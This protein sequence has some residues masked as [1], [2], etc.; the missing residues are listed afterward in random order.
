MKIITDDFAL[1]EI[2]RL[3]PAELKIL[4]SDF[5]RAGGEVVFFGSFPADL[6]YPRDNH[7]ISDVDVKVFATKDKIEKLKEILL[8]Y[9]IK[10]KKNVEQI[11]LDMSYKAKPE[12]LSFDISLSIMRLERDLLK[13]KE[14]K[15]AEFLD[16]FAKKLDFWRNAIFYHYGSCSFY[17]SANAEKDFE[18]NTISAVNDNV[19]A[20]LKRY[21]VRHVV[22]L[23]KLIAK[24]PNASLSDSIVT[25]LQ[26]KNLS[27][28][29]SDRQWKKNA[30]GKILVCL[31]KAYGAGF[32]QIFFDGVNNKKFNPAKELFVCARY[33]SVQQEYIKNALV[34]LSQYLHKLHLMQQKISIFKLQILFD[35]VLLVGPFMA[36]INQLRKTNPEDWHQYVTMVA[37]KLLA[38]QRE[39]IPVA[40]ESLE[41]WIV[42]FLVRCCGE[43]TNKINAGYIDQEVWGLLQ[44]FVDIKNVWEKIEPENHLGSIKLEEVP[45]ETEE[46]SALEGDEELFDHELESWLIS[47]NLNEGNIKTTSD[48]E[49]SVDIGEAVKAIASVNSA[50]LRSTPA[51]MS[52]TDTPAIIKIP[53]RKKEKP[54]SSPPKQTQ[55]L[56]VRE[57]PAPV[58]SADQLIA[59]TELEKVFDEKWK[60]I[61]SIGKLLVEEN[62]W[63]F[64][65]KTL[66]VLCGEAIPQNKYP[67]IHPFILAI[68]RASFLF[69][70]YGIK[71]RIDKNFQN[72][73][74]E[75]F[76]DLVGN[77]FKDSCYFLALD[78]FDYCLARAILAG[79]NIVLKRNF[80]EPVKDVN[81]TAQQ[82]VN[83]QVEVLQTVAEELPRHYRHPFLTAS[84]LLGGD[85]RSGVRSGHFA[86]GMMASCSGLLADHSLSGIIVTTVVSI[87]LATVVYYFDNLSARILDLRYVPAGKKNEEVESLIGYAVPRPR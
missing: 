87:L 17:I 33:Q 69:A 64:K 49:Q 76:K 82:Q 52:K 50:D 53:K 60:Q 25:A 43:I 20:D 26:D 78:A 21:P 80:S 56:P 83:S 68:A 85:T 11:I 70:L 10:N 19:K 5:Q 42:R 59:P 40:N 28:D 37:K 31:S 27:N 51:E 38:K 81:E 47:I 54:P 74:M 18:E 32:I 75:E 2:L 12:Q 65:I 67:L 77:Y 84:A 66:K 1:M 3:V 30:R 36:E 44:S 9:F 8:N 72:A 4:F 61:K 24:Y 16:Q 7:V 71:L 15:L 48:S 86:I 14:Q 45:I 29:E 79:K 63:I 58:H 13:T 23:L 34:Q 73:S 55:K 46:P 57:Q 41:Q 62:K 39:A 6:R 22:N 35:T